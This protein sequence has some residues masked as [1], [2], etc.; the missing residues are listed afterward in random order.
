MTFGGLLKRFREE[1]KY[2]LRDLGKLSDINHAYIHRLETGAKEAPSEEVL[3]ALVKA[4]KLDSRRARVLK[5]LVGRSVDD[6]LVEVFLDETDYTPDDFESGAEMSYRGARPTSKE[7][8]RRLLNRLRK[9]R[10]EFQ[11]DR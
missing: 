11:D 5:F 10:E 9:M 4:L 7:A 6:L 8:W 1:R 3:A 2:T